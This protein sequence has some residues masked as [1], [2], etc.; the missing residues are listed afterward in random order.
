MNNKRINSKNKCTHCQSYIKKIHIKCIDCKG[1]FHLKCADVKLKNLK[2]LVFNFKCQY[3]INF[4]C[5]KCVKPVLNHH[6]A[7]FCD[8]CKKW[9]HLKCSGMTMFQYQQLS[10]QNY[11]WY[12]SEC[13]Q[14]PFSTNNDEVFF[15]LFDSKAQKSINH[16]NVIEMSSKCSI[17]NKNAKS[18][19]IKNKMIPCFGCNSLIHKKCSGLTIREIFN[20]KESFSL[21]QCNSCM[22]DKFPLCNAKDEELIALGFNSNVSCSCKTTNNFQ[23]HERFSFKIDAEDDDSCSNQGPDAENYLDSIY[24]LT[25]SFDYYNIHDLHKISLNKKDRNSSLVS[26]FHTNIQSLMHN[27]EDLE[28]L[29]N[30]IEKPKFHLVA[31]SETWNPSHKANTFRPGILNGYHPYQGTQ[32]NSLKSGCGF[33]IRSDLNFI[34]RKDLNISIHDEHNEFQSNW[35]EIINNKGKNI[36]A[37][38]FYRHPRKNSDNT[39]IKH[40]QEILNKIKIENKLILISGDFNYNLLNSNKCHLTNEFIETMYSNYFQPCIIEP[41]RI[42]PGQKPSLIDNIFV[43]TIGKTIVSGNIYNKISDHM[44]NFVIINEQNA[45]KANHKKVFR[46]MANFNADDFNNDVSKIHLS[47]SD[48]INTVFDNFQEQYIKILDNHAPWKTMSKKDCK[49]S[50]KPWFTKGLRKSIKIKDLYYGKFMRTKK[51]DWY[52]LYK[53]YRKMIKRL[54]FLSKQSYYKSYFENNKN[55]SRKTWDGIRNIINQSHK[56]QNNNIFL[57]YKGKTIFDQKS[58]AN[59][60]NQHYSTIADKLLSK[61]EKPTCEY[62]DFLKNPNKNELYLNEIEPDEIRKMINDLDTKKSADIYGISP[63]FL[64]ASSNSLSMLLSPIF[65]LSLFT[66]KFPDSL[67]VAK[68]IPVFKSG[69]KLDP[70][71]YRPISLLPLFSKLLEKIMHA[72]LYKYLEEENIIYQQQY[73]F[74]KNKSTEHAILSIQSKIVQSLEKKE[75]P[76]CVFLDFAKA[77]DTVNHDILL[78]KLEYYGVRGTSLDWFKSYLDNR[79]QCVHCNETSD[80]LPITCGVPQGSI[81]GP[82]LFLIY[83]NDIPNSSDLINFQLFAD[84][85][86]LFYSHKNLNILEKTFNEELIRINDW[87]LANKLSLNVDKSNTILFRPKNQREGQLISLTLNGE[88]IKERISAKYLGIFFDNKLLW[89]HQIEHISKK[90]I[91]SNAL[92]AKLRH[93][94]GHKTLTNLY[95]S[96]IQPHI[97]YGSLIWGT[98]AQTNLSKLESLQN[99]ALRIMCFKNS[100]E[101]ATPLYKHEKILPLL[102]NTILNQG[103]FLWKYTHDLLPKCCNDTLTEFGVLPYGRENNSYKLYTPFQRT[104]YG[105]KFLGYSGVRTWNMIVPDNIRNL[106]FPKTFNKS[107]KKYLNSII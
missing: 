14:F 87:L 65:N 23:K 97:D 67:K 56:K 26:L 10:K 107:F 25:P 42:V 105:V 37:A 54:T 91:K 69:S 88:A 36:L 31:L 85:T 96:L 100:R 22:E 24:D 61:L 98:A 77:F 75:T 81:L 99:K 30:S 80:L 45:E 21:W 95:N 84:D 72:R 8:C 86:C 28:L 58:V 44:P 43:N 34:N 12:C 55:N 71:N 93:F 74:Q 90:L 33:Y 57:N 17:C 104:D 41:T 53:K 50:L 92:L 89:N 62:Q 59:T 102:H 83:I 60:F 7:I 20:F 46:N 66:G 94:V 73:G 76:C 101:S 68:V 40:L 9:I 18:E 82:I 27:S 2:S 32:G 47:L 11:D 64:K 103:K 19:T 52:D 70:I 106:P 5:I 15:K 49:W 79:K 3:C 51:S 1:Y 4:P 16:K 13:F 6:K 63:T 78:H 35:V 39:F 48:D 29:L 38:V